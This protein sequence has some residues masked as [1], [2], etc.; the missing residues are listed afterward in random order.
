M[1]ELRLRRRG[2]LGAQRLRRQPGLEQR[3]QVVDE[4]GQAG[5][6]DGP[7]VDRGP[8]GESLV[9]A[10]E[11]EPAQPTAGQDGADHHPCR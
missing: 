10:V 11:D 9:E 8:S 2:P 1:H 6:E 3:E 7:G 4:D 5:H